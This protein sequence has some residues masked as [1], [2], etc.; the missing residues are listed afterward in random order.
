[1]KISAYSHLLLNLYKE[2][3]DLPIDVFQ[4]TVLSSLQRLLPFDSSMWGH[5]V[6]KEEGLDIHSIHLF[7]TTPAMLEEYAKVKHLDCAA[8]AMQAAANLTLAFRNSQVFQGDERRGIREFCTR[9]GHENFWISSD[10]HPKTGFAQ[11]ISLYRKDPHQVCTADET[12]LLSDLAPHLMQALAMNRIIHSER[13]LGDSARE[14]WCT[15]IVDQRAV[16][17]YCDPRFADLL[18]QEWPGHSTE[19]APAAIKAKFEHNRFQFIGKKSFIDGRLEKDLFFLRARQLTQA[20][21]LSPT[22]LTVARL[23]TAG[24]THKGIAQVLDRSPETI[25]THVKSIFRKLNIHNAA[26]LASLLQQTD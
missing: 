9:F 11:W 13:L 2:A 15:A 1:M 14:K 22:E 5:G 8:T 12:E 20:D 23:L 26:A 24:K 17:H 4:D 6:L 25:R 18:Q 10:I 19:Y 21:S 7:N 3:Q 16:F